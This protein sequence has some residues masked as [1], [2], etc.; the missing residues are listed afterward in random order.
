M[1]GGTPTPLRRGKYSSNQPKAL[2]YSSNQRNSSHFVKTD[3]GG[4]QKT[5]IGGIR[6]Q[7]DQENT[8]EMNDSERD[9]IPQKKSA[10]NSF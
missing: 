10:S 7:K 8:P 2:K 3:I 6:N 1:H 5:D 9:P 4:I